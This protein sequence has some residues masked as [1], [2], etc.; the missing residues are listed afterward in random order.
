MSNSKLVTYTNFSPKCSSREGNSISRI[1]IHHMACVSTAK[2]CADNHKSCNRDVSA[3]YYIGKD[4][5]MAQGVDEKYRPWT[6][7]N[8][9]GD[10]R[11]VT[12]EVSNSVNGNPYGGDGWKVS[13]KSFA[14]LVDLC[15]DI[16]KRNGIKELTFTGNKDKDTLSCHKQW[17]AATVCPGDYL[18]SKLP[19]LCKKVNEILNPK[20]KT[21][22]TYYVQIGAFSTKKNAED[23]V[24]KAK[25]AGFNAVIK[26]ETKEIK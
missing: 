2:N 19:E 14:S 22:T 10:I 21:T 25:K 7:T 1:I 26:S 23:Y 8:K 5:D 13:D 12:I 20:P 18:Y 9:N 15:A 11:A 16:C 4:G 24:E 3:T 17:Y 6:S